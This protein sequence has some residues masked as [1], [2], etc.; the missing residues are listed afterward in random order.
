MGIAGKG[1]PEPKYKEK[2]KKLSGL[3][4]WVSKP[5]GLGS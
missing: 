5:P 1:W 4:L 3:G 2:Q